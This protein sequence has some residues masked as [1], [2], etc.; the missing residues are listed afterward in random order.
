MRPRRSIVSCMISSLPF[1]S[2]DVIGIVARYTTCALATPGSQAQLL[3]SFALTPASNSFH[4]LAVAPDGRIWCGSDHGCHILPVGGELIQS[5][6]LA[7]FQP[8]IA[9]D[10]AAGEVFCSQSDDSKRVFV[11]RMDGSFVRA[12]RWDHSDLPLQCP[13]GLAMNTTGLL[14][15]LDRKNGVQVRRR[16][17]EYVTEFG[18]GIGADNG[19][20]RTPSCLALSSSG[21]GELFVGDAGNH[22]VQVIVRTVSL[23]KIFVA[24]CHCTA[25][26]FTSRYTHTYTYT[27]T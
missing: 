26:G 24:C 2:C 27:F 3:L 15:V 16:N 13:V 21:T 25:C 23:C 20:L 17:G 19:Q 14:L 18:T 11:Y 9:F 1:F 8:A 4:R 10:K 22:R 6:A 5:V 7:P 12:F